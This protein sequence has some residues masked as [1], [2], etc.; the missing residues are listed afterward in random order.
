MKSPMWYR[1]ERYLEFVKKFYDTI[2]GT[3][4]QYDNLYSLQ[5]RYRNGERTNELYN[6][7]MDLT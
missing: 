2:G 5:R 1:A 7:I 6:E 3:K 4:E